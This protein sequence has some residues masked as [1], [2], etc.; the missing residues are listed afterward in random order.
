MR[1]LNQGREPLGALIKER[2]IYLFHKTLGDTFSSIGRGH[3]EP[4]D[5]TPP[6][7][8]SADHGTNEPPFDYRDDKNCIWFAHQAR[9]SFYRVENTGGSDFGFDPELV[10][11]D[12]II[13]VCRHWIDWFQVI[14]QKQGRE[15]L[16]EIHESG[17]LGS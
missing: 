3:S 15:L 7:I 2:T 1:M 4:I 12:E 10:D 11:G 6:S 5:V 9:Q 8:P 16:N 14:G 17:C 13:L